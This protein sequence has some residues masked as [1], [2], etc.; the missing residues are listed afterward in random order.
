MPHHLRRSYYRPRITWTTGAVTQNV[1]RFCFLFS[2]FSHRSSIVLLLS[3]N[4]FD[5]FFLPLCRRFHTVHRAT[6]TE[7][8]LCYDVY[9][10]SNTCCM[11]LLCMFNSHLE[12]LCGY[13]IIVYNVTWCTKL[14]KGAD[15]AKKNTVTWPHCMDK[16][17]VNPRRACAARVTVLGL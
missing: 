3:I 8:K 17:I 5:T 10:S 15:I 16:L 2:L 11:R 7:R 6:Q 4:R 1:Y 9:C 13:F 12:N 14:H